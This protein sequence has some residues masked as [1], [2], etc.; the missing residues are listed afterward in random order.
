MSRLPKVV[1][2]T[3]IQPNGEHISKSRTQAKPA[4]S[5][6]DAYEP[7]QQCMQQ[8]MLRTTQHG[9]N[10]DC[11]H[12]RHALMDMRDQ[13]VQEQLSQ[14]PPVKAVCLVSLVTQVVS[15]ML[16]AF[17]HCRP[18]LLI[19]SSNLWSDLCNLHACST[20]SCIGSHHQKDLQQLFGRARTASSEYV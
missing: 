1:G 4:Q 12:I 16:P 6:C 18:I 11:F 20:C 3:A 7:C 19:W 13:L 5:S 15:N 2:G 8:H 10:I 9:S 17:V 14:S